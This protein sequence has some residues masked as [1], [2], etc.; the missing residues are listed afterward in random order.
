MPGVLDLEPEGTEED[1]IGDLGAKTLD[2]VVNKLFQEM[3]DVPLPMFAS[4]TNYLE[5]G[6]STW[7][8]G[9]YPLCQRPLLCIQT[10]I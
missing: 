10:D 2:E 1:I 3:Q 5:S 4:A 8:K 7:Y 6:A 9:N